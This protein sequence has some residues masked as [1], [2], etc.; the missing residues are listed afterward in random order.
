VVNLAVKSEKSVEATVS[1]DQ[2]NVPVVN[3]E[4]EV[5]HADDNKAKED[6]ATADQ[7]KKSTPKKKPNTDDKRSKSDSPSVISQILLWVIVVMLIVGGFSY[8]FSAPKYAKITTQDG[9]TLIK[10]DKVKS[11]KV[12]E[13][14]QIVHLDLKDNFSKDYP[15]EVHV[16][17]DKVFFYYVRDQGAMLWSE[18]KDRQFDEGYDMLVPQSSIFD[19]LFSVLLP[20][21]IIFGLFYFV[22]TKMGGEGNPLNFASMKKRMAN[23]DGETP[24][25]TFKDVA[26]IDEAVEEMTEIRDFMKEPEKYHKIGAKIPKG[27]LLYGPPGTGKTLLAKAVAGEAKVPFFSISGSDFVEMFVGVGASRVRDLFKRAKQVAPSII[28]IDEIDAVGRHRGSGVGGG[29]DEREQ[30]LNQMLV[31]MDGFDDMTNILLIAATNRPDILDPALLR[32]GRFDR[33]IAVDA[34]DMKGRLAILEVYAKDK[35]FADDVDLEMIAKRTPGYTGA[36]LAN[37]I[38]EAALLTVRLGKDKIG[39]DELDESIDRVMAGPQRKS[40]KMNDNDL[41][42]TAFHEAG[43]A[44][45]AAAMHYTD[46]VNKVTILPRGKALGYTSVMPS[47]DRYSVTR[48]QLLDQMAYAMGGRV[49][50]EMIFKDPSTGASN[51]I[52]KATDIARKMVTLYGMTSAVGPVKVGADDNDRY[53]PGKAESFATSSRVG[54]LVDQQVHDLLENAHHEARF[55]IS[56]NLDVLNNLANQLLEKE[57]L[58]EDELNEI[59]KDMRRWGEREVWNSFSTRT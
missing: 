54:D 48:N 22:M 21:L 58:L 10:E 38:N 31:E 33:Q 3:A 25:I 24:K 8:F 12:T 14:E 15:E 46:P 36:D 37:V 55:V 44:V 43:H 11:V 19:S 39:T 5:K 51:D 16:D 26:G 59:F 47:E 28:F 32:P 40:R 53:K 29:H 9:L 30:T 52:E 45:V 23:F 56:E 34:P 2:V 20:M 49:A 57:T 13:F 50:E 1:T 27:V 18:I 41:K 4:D 35:P 17:A 6:T 42:N 7:K